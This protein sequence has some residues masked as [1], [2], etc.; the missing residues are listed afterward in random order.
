MQGGGL[1]L[2]NES[3]AAVNLAIGNV[4]TL[5]SLKMVASLNDGSVCS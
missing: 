1:G 3:G 5:R 2:H 4:C